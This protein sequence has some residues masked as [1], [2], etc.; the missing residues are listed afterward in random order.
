MNCDSLHSV[1][2]IEAIVCFHAVALDQSQDKVGKSTVKPT[3][4]SQMLQRPTPPKLLLL[5]EVKKTYD[6]ISG[7][8]G[9]IT[10]VTLEAVETDRPQIS[11][12]SCEGAASCDRN[13]V[14]S[15]PFIYLRFSKICELKCAM[16]KVP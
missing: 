9:N 10:T 14:E 11:L 3:G 8:F 16:T 13:Q 4:H 6:D 15:V 7:L 12:Y 1:V 5:I 2:L